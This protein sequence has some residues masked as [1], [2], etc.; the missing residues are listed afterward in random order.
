MNAFYVSHFILCCIPFNISIHMSSCVVYMLHISNFNSFLSLPIQF[1]SLFHLNCNKKRS[2]NRKKVAMCVINKG[3]HAWWVFLCLELNGMTFA[4]FML[5][6]LAA[7][8]CID[9]LRVKRLKGNFICIQKTRPFID[10]FL[11][12]IWV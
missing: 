12:L 4:K 9:E 6:F 10:L 1:C 2:F 3:K 7:L 11:D 5:F 8:R